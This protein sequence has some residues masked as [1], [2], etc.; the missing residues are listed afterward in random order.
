MGVWLTLTIRLVG[1]F[2]GTCWEK[3]LHFGARA[4]G[5]GNCF[6]SWRPGIRERPQ[7][8]GEAQRTGINPSSRG[9]AI[10]QKEAQRAGERPQ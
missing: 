10:E 4:A 7:Q 8:Q 9:E 1:G 5:G 6:V 2:A 3:C